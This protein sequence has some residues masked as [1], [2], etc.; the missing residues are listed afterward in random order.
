MKYLIAGTLNL[1]VTLFV[2]KLP[3]PGGE[4]RV[5]KIK[6]ALGGKGGNI[7]S[8][9]AKIT[10]EASFLG[11]LGNDEA[12]QMHLDYFKSIN[13]DTRFIK[14]YDGASSGTSYVIVEEGTGENMVLSYLG[15]NAMLTPEILDEEILK[16]LKE[17]KVVIAANVKPELAKAIFEASKGLS[18]YVPASYVK[19]SCE[20]KPKYLIVNEIESQSLEGCSGARIIRT[21]GSR[22]AE[23]F[24][25]GIRVE[26]V[27]LEKLGLKPVSAVGAGDAFAG[28]FSAALALGYTDEEALKLANYAAALK[29]T[30][31]DPR[32]S[33]TK[34]ELIK[35]L[36]QADPK[37]NLRGLSSSLV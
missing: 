32:G 28:A 24:G 2:N 31:E 26:A 12:A 21:L 11:A 35:F 22:G 14:I 3:E 9:F 10:G 36:R 6:K 25:T 17:A 7:A 15:A 16:E 29:V 5:F 33:P 27:N 30:K 8:A 1:D 20:A 18:V 34:E 37:F 19:S 13:V 23:I 4:T